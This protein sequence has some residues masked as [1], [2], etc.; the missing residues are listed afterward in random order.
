MRLLAFILS[1]ILLNF[2]S[3]QST[4]YS[5]GSGQASTMI[6]ADDGNIL[7]LSRADGGISLKKISGGGTIIWNQIYMDEESDYHSYGSR[8]VESLTWKGL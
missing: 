1:F 5:F 2:I 4:E 6:V 3:A 7:M 8:I